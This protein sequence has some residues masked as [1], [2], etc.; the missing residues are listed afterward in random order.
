MLIL[1]AR[2]EAPPVYAHVPLLHG[3]DG[4]KLSTRHGAASVQEL[5]DAGYLPEAV[6]NYIALLGWGL[7]ETTTF[8]TTDELVCNFGLELVSRNPAL[9]VVQIHRQIFVIGR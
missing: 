4:A 7:D 2:G 9:S 5:R 6:R 8:L 3:P 1:A